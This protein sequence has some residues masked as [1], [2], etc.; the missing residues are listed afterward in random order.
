MFK[1]YQKAAFGTFDPRVG[2]NFDPTLLSKYNG[3]DATT[4]SGAGYTTQG[5]KPGQKMQVN[6]TLT[7]GSAG[8]LTFELWYYLN[9]MIRVLNPNFV[10]GAYTYVPQNSYEGIKSIAAGTDGTV[11]FDEN[12]DCVI[13]NATP[14]NALGRISCDEIAYASFFEA[15]ATTPFVVAWFRYTVT[16]DA[17]IDKTFKW[18]VKTF[19]GGVKENT[20]SPRSYFDPNQFQANT[21]DILTTFDVGID[22]GLQVQLLAA[23][24]VRLAL[25]IQFWTNQTLSE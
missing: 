16:S 22:R 4:G 10:T 19:S 6:L 23:E 2:N 9:S 14:G 3:A 13:R 11:G 21:I 12:G 7:N 1:A 5:A 24:S 8:L 17:Q 25:F 20:I 15:S 18:K